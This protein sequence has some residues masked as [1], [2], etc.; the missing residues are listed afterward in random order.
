MPVE[1]LDIELT[2]RLSTA[3]F[4]CDS[5]GFLLTINPVPSESGTSFSG[6]LILMCSAWKLPSIIKPRI[7]RLLLKQIVGSFQATISIDTPIFILSPILREVDS[8]LCTQGTE[9]SHRT[10][11]WIFI[12]TIPKPKPLSSNE[13]SPQPTDS[14]QLPISVLYLEVNSL[15][16][17]MLA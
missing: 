4:R 1:S 15:S 2:C 3:D 6:F 5:Y 10:W 17:Y 14:Q 16:A 9:Y 7:K 11:L 12:F 8:R 13:S